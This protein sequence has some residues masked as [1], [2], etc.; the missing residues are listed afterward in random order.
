MTGTQIIPQNTLKN[1]THSTPWTSHQKQ[2]KKWILN[3]IL[4]DKTNSRSK[5]FNKNSKTWILIKNKNKKWKS[6]SNSTNTIP[7]NSEKPKDNTQRLHKK[8]DRKETAIYIQ[9]WIQFQIILEHHTKIEK[10]Q[11]RRSAC[12][13]KWWHSQIVQWS[14]KQKLHATVLPA[15]ILKTIITNIRKRMLQLHRK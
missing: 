8:S 1:N 15:I 13:K 10:K 14:W 4:N 7:R 3:T 5:K 12:I 9:K 11:C 2:R 6:Y